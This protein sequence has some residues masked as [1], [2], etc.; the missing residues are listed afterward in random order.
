MISIRRLKEHVLKM[1]ESSR[2]RSI[3]LMEKDELPRNEF[4][5]KLDVWLRLLTLE[6]GE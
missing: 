2:L 1:P 6:Y 4:L 5:A 3:I